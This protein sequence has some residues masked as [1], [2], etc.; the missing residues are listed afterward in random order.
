MTDLDD[1]RDAVIADLERRFHD[2]YLDHWKEY[3]HISPGDVEQIYAH[4][5]RA[6]GLYEI[7]TGEE[8]R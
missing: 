5:F 7:E 2:W 3:R 4:G 1:E 6:G 8:R